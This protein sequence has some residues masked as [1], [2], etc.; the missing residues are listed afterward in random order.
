[1]GP[2]SYR[3]RMDGPGINLSLSLLPLTFTTRAASFKSRFDLGSRQ[4]MRKWLVNDI[5]LTNEIHDL[6]P[7]PD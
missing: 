4:Q 7:T 3:L 5:L 1:M 6:V 2:I